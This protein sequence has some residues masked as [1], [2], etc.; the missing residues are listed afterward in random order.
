[1]VLSH[2]NRP[3]PFC[4]FNSLDVAPNLLLLLDAVCAQIIWA[5]WGSYWPFRG[6]S[7]RNKA[8]N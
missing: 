4:Q 7:M 8:V 1:M 3:L 6:L 2:A 5:G